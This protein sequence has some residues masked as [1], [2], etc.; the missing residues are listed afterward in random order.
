MMIVD[1]LDQ[2]INIKFDQKYDQNYHI[3]LLYYSGLPETGLGTENPVRT[4]RP[5]G[6]PDLI[7]ILSKQKHEIFVKLTDLINISKKLII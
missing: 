2:N 6:Q 1:D 7:K 4:A 5:C 3:Y